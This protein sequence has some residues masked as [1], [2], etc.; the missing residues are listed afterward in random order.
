M[1]DIGP[2]LRE[3][4]LRAGWDISEVEERT[5]IRAKYLRALENEEWSLLPGPTFTKGFLR[6][7]A[8]NLGLDWRLLIDEYKRQW[9]QPNELDHVPVRPT[10]G[11]ETRGRG[12]RRLRRLAGALA[13]AAALAVAVVLIGR[14]G[15]SPTTPPPVHKHSASLRSTGASG[16]TATTGAVTTSCVPGPAG[17][18]AASCVS[19]RI[20]PRVTALYVC[21]VGDRRIRI[22]GRRLDPATPRPTYHAHTFVVTL[23][24]SNAVLVVNAHR[25]V[26][27]AATGAVRYEI[28]PHRRRRLA[29]PTTLHCAA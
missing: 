3:A 15:S 25:F 11:Y 24:S 4:R 26:I 10:L 17:H 6:T 5:K 2:T 27:P 21:L 7:Y 1:T 16:R 20:E 28:T 9:E 8:E 12:Q 18:L 22:D 23:G 29:A 19:L 13:L 14:L